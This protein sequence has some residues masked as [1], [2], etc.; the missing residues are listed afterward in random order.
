[1]K[2]NN[3]TLKIPF[4]RTL[5]LVCMDIMAIMASSF[6]A[7]YIRYEFSFRAIQP[8]FMH[9]YERVLPFNICFTLMLFVLFKLYRSVWRYAGHVVCVKDGNYYDTWQSGDE[10]PIYAWV[11][12]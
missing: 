4:N 8:R 10:V 2:Q 6:A 12:E 1:M 7:L 11:K 5:A 3:T 9:N